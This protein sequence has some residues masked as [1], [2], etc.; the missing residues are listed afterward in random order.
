MFT[1]LPPRRFRWSAGAAGR[2][3]PSRVPAPHSRNV[4]SRTPQNL[5]SEWRS[6]AEDGSA[7][8][9]FHWI[10][11]GYNVLK[12]MAQGFWGPA[13]L[14]K[15]G[16]H[17]ITRCPSLFSAI[18]RSVC[19]PLPVFQGAAFSS[20]HFT[21]S[22]PPRN[23]AEPGG[24]PPLWGS[25]AA[26]LAVLCQSSASGHRASH[27]KYTRGQSRETGSLSRSPGGVGAPAKLVS[28]GPAWADSGSVNLPRRW[29]GS[30]D[31][32][33]HRRLLRQS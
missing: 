30:E 5:E 14:G 19:Q 31:R 7:D 15:S 12:P 29:R 17:C 18:R 8:R 20:E 33:F 25:L 9:H 2:S 13:P 11:F 24:S 10:F 23:V 32:R 28:L 16:V 6:Q 27:S 26:K 4:I 3:S 1:P 21:Q 22:L